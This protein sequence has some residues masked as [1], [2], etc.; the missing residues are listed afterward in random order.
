MADDKVIIDIQLNDGQVKNVFNS[1]TKSAKESSKEASSNLDE[2]LGGSF[3]KLAATAAA[4]GAAIGAALFSK[5]SVQA[6]MEAEAG[7]QRLNQSL[8]NAG[9]FSLEASQSFQDLAAEIQRTTTIEDDAVFSI[10][11]LANNFAKSTVQAQN[12]TKAAIELSAA[13]GKDLNSSVEILGKTLSGSAGLLTK[14]L[15]ELQNF[16][17]QQLKAGAAIDAVLNRFGGSAASQVN[18]FSGA[19]EQAKNNF[20]DLQEEVGNFIVKD[21]V[22]VALLQSISQA[23]ASAASSVAKFR[24]EGEGSTSFLGNMIILSVKVFEAINKFLI[25]P[26]EVF[27]NLVKLGAQTIMTTITAVAA[28]FVNLANKFTS[29]LPD[30][31]PFKQFKENIQAD[32]NSINTELSTQF[33]E[34][35]TSAD[36]ALNVK[37]AGSTA[38]FLEDLRTKLENAK[39][40]SADF[41]NNVNADINQ[42]DEN[43]K[44]RTDSI[45]QTFSQGLVNMI[46][47]SMGKIGQSL[48]KGSFSFEEFAGTVL[49]AL[50]DMSI[51]IG[52]NLVAQGIGINALASALAT[53]N[54]GAAI[55]A[56]AALIALGGALKALSGGMGGGSPVGAPGTPGGSPVIT[57]PMTETP[58]DQTVQDQAPQNDVTVN[59]RGDVLDSDETGLR[60]VDIINTAF[61]K[62]GVVIK[63][64]VTA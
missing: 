17:K 6:A 56:G 2:F 51:A 34:L 15:P 52:T 30:I 31:G 47:Q 38:L 16:T 23:F 57:S 12:L 45:N 32:A 39:D 41:K 24:T 46:A 62:Q 63:R 28:G 7:V 50:G 55:A 44:K 11:A 36:N 20:G 42:I 35:A 37:F 58:L 13:T 1:L 43:L 64:G 3:T 54:G 21:K 60:I 18:T 59:I 40:V 33:D 48:A 9:R 27:V 14:Q 8:A 53:L 4:A 19:L 29:L 10:A 61:D 49:G 5:A 22:F 25:A 26:F